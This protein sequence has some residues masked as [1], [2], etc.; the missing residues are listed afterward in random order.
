M[1]G[2]ITGTRYLKQTTTSLGGTG[3]TGRS[4][5]RSRKSKAAKK[6]KMFRAPKAGGG[7]LIIPLKCGYQYEVVGTGSSFV[8]LDA[9]VGLEFM[10]NPDWYNRY[11]PIFDWVK[12]N[13]VRIEVTCPYNIGQAGV[14]GNSLFS[15]WSKKASSVA[16]IPPTT[17]NEWMNMQNAKRNTFS[18]NNNSVEYYFTP[19][20]EAPQGATIAKRLMYKRWFEVPS[21]PTGAVSHLG[22]IAHIVKKDGSV[23]PS[24]N[25][26]KVN[27]TLYCQMKGVKQL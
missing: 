16:E 20:F 8:P 10:P 23:I 14:G 11:N 25:V 18:G 17:L 13:K 5:K 1:S 15:I 6:M 22:M 3:H 2:V 26:F 21:G 19:A 9:N 7:S 27:V 24:S 12:I 4:G